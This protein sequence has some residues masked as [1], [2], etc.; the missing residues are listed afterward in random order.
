M[1]HSAPIAMNSMI[2]C[3]YVCVRS[4]LFLIGVWICTGF[5]ESVSVSCRCFDTFY[6][7]ACF[8]MEG[9]VERVNIIDLCFNLRLYKDVYI[10]TKHR[11]LWVLIM[12]FNIICCCF[13]LAW[14]SDGKS[15]IRVFPIFNVILSID[16]SSDR[17]KRFELLNRLIAYHVWTTLP[18]F[19][20]MLRKDT[21]VQAQYQCVRQ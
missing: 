13:G 18:L 12:D 7:S 6:K 15:L 4:F 21:C 2:S 5:V 11:G 20:F 3:R 17:T 16:D 19:L 14:M 8:C 9:S 10:F 1:S